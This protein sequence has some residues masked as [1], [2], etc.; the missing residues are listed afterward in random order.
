[1]TTKLFLRTAYFL[2]AMTASSGL[3]AQVKVG[4]NPTTINPNSNL[5]VEATSGKKVIVHKDNG[6]VVI[7]NTP[8]GAPTDSLMTIDATGNVRRRSPASLVQASPYIKTRGTIFLNAQQ[9]NVVSFI[10]NQNV[11]LQHDITYNAGSGEIVIVK[12]GIYYVSSVSTSPNTYFPNAADHCSYIYINGVRDRQVCAGAY[13]GSSVVIANTSIFA[14]NA[15]DR[16]TVG[17]STSSVVPNAG[18]YEYVVSLYKLG[19]K[20]N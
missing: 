14:L 2:A 20:V 3:F 5:E 10:T 12:P 8:S 9:S 1:M 15:G 6:T 4:S 17:L 7:E 18:T 19:E 16:I 11:L 13:N